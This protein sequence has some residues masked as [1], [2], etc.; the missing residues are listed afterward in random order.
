MRIDAA[1]RTVLE[2]GTQRATIDGPADLALRGDDLD[3][4]RVVLADCGALPPCQVRT[5]TEIP[6][7][8]GI[9][10]STALV[11]AL[12]AALLEWKGE[13][14]ALHALAERAREIERS[15]LGVQCGFVDQY[16]CSFGGIR[17]VELRGKERDLPAE[18]TPWA[19]V[20]DLAPFV[21]EP[22][23]VVAFT[24]VQHSSGAVHRPIRE[25]WLSFA[26]PLDTEMRV[27][28]PDSEVIG[29]FSGIDERGSLLLETDG[30]SR[31]IDM[32][33]VF[34]L[35]PANTRSQAY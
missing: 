29:R 14:P 3:L 34:P 4:A 22:P 32:G 20:E 9:A 23:F 33:D 2:S 25:R 5:E 27:R 28:L 1:E 30:G 21:P 19:T 31:R 13:R 7:Q 24:G 26:L 11:V 12:T 16:C 8:S 18:D 15:G 35:P 10:G 17:F 6:R